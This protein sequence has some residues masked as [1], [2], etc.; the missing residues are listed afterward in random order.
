MTIDEALAM[1]RARG[2]DRL[3]AAVLLAHVTGRSRTWL[4]AHGGDDLAATAITAFQGLCERRHGGEPLAYLTGEREFFGLRL[5]VSPA[6]LVP[7]PDTELLVDWALE[8]LDRPLSGPNPSVVDL[9][10][11]SGAI[12]LALAS[13]RPRARVTATDTNGSALAVALENGRRLGLSVRWRLG[14]WWQAVA[15]ER[16]DLA[17]SNPPYVA[18]H[19][20]HLA[21]LAHEP[22]SALVAGELGLADL[23]RI[24]ELA[25]AHVSGWLLVEHGWDQ[26]EA[27]RG[28]LRA[29]G[30]RAVETRLDL[31]G[32]A[33]CTGGSWTPDR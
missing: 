25:P 28:L 5:A 14:D 7:R 29:A 4:M 23:R 1:A 16:F 22:R 6:V 26:A 10:T 33:R 9:G 24:V 30:A 20:P 12:A 3:D 8:L 15:G 11:G 31:A 18:E 27:V 21:A 32:H 13:R 2:V 19:D 17:V